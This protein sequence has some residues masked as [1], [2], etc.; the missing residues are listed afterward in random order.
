MTGCRSRRP[1]TTCPEGVLVD[2]DGATALPGLWA[3]GEVACS[4]VH[5]ANRLAS[6]SLLEG[7]VFGA[8]CVDAILS[9]RDAPEPTGALAGLDGETAEAWAT[10]DAAA[11]IAVRPV[12][13]CRCGPE[14]GWRF[15]P[16]GPAPRRTAHASTGAQRA[17]LQAAMTN[18]AGVVRDASSLGRASDAVAGVVAELALERW[19]VPLP[20]CG[21]SPTS[22]RHCWRPRPSVRRHVDRRHVGLPGDVAELPLQA[23]ARGEP[24]R[25]GHGAA[26]RHSSA[27][28]AHVTRSVPVHRD[29]VHPPV[30]AVREAVAVALAE[31]LLPLGDLSAAL[32]PESP[33]ARAAFVARAPGVVAGTRCAEQTCIQVDP[34]LEVTWLV[35]EGRDIG[36]QGVIGRVEGRLRSLLTAERTALE[37]PL[38]SLGCC[39]G[40]AALCRGRA[41]GPTRQRGSGTRAR[42][43]LVC[44]RSRR[45]L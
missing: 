39:D 24:R 21:T 19:T 37:F 11:P 28:P 45:R 8:R 27:V 34:G 38:P 32:I 35:E 18:W 5:G 9:G 44:G 10:G 30:A 20:R 2:L 17:A 31:D 36:S 4:G 14:R 1:R 41:A 12:A 42:P 22:P 6:N 13:D 43:R 16:R 23:V 3:A 33:A 40:H 25:A 15:R 7:M 26:S 29:D